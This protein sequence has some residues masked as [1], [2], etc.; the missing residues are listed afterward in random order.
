MNSL[1]CNGM[2][3]SANPRQGVMSRM[4]AN[5]KAMVHL[6]PVTCSSVKDYCTAT[7]PVLKWDSLPL[8]DLHR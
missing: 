3:R 8:A 1:G 6:F 5:P 2:S 4:E 7:V